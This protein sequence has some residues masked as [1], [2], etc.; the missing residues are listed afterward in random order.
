MHYELALLNS[1]CDSG[2]I[3]PVI[4]SGGDIVFD[5]Y[6]DVWSWT[7]EFYSKYEKIPSKQILKEHFPSF[8]FIDTS[9]APLQYYIDDAKKQALSTTVRISIAKAI[10]ILK[11]N[12]PNAA[13]N[14]L[15][16]TGHTIMKDVGG[17]KDTNLVGEYHER[18]DAYRDR[19]E[20]PE[21][22]I[23]GITSGTKV[24]DKIWGGWQK[25]DL[26]VLM[27]TPGC[28]KTWL[29]RLFAI[30]A[31]RAGYTSLIISLEM[32]KEQEGYRM[33]TILNEGEYFTSSD[34]MNGIN[35]SPEEY[36]RWA[37]EQFDGKPPIYLVTAEGMETA[38]Q[39]MV[40]AKIDQYKP[41]LLIVDYFNIME[42][43]RGGGTETDRIRNLFKDHK[44]MAV[45]N[46]IPIIG[47]SAV[48]MKGEDYGTRAPELSE[49]AWS[50]HAAHDCDLVLAIHRHE[51]SQIFE[52]VARK[53]RRSQQFAFFL[54][55]S[56]NTGKWKELF[57]V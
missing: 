56:L 45:K 42:D 4:E 37:K 32:S 48:T 12:G 9:A 14:Y 57:D 35:L 22:H 38:N 11:E 15:T 46:Q 6:K 51:N 21:T 1:I 29:S 49:L 18:V 33:D 20:S 31:W 26:V 23:S 55:W 50:K 54:D 3:I 41:D 43:A 27:G 2:E 16:S 39:H 7:Y 28:G 36:E 52:I 13:L 30:N 10:E 47:I 24:I 19:F 53:A 40:Q 44:R 8:E 34:L 17:L 5:Q 25:G